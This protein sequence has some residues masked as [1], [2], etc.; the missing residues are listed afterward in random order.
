[1]N[2]FENKP[3]A[4]IDPTV[5]ELREELHS[6]RTLVSTS[7]IV[8]IVFVCCLNFFLMR[9]AS[10]VRNEVTRN[11]SFLAEFGPWAKTVWDRLKDYSKTHTDFA[12]IISKYNAYVVEGPPTNAAPPV[13]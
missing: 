4:A 6:L 11:E 7:L 3:D 8:L 5:Q 2:E 9:Q 10:T 1:M 13:K 12:P